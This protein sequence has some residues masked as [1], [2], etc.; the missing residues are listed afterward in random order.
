MLT[1]I[2]MENFEE[3]NQGILRGGRDMQLRL[4]IFN[5]IV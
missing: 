4:Q 1:T 3:A 5:M 2:H